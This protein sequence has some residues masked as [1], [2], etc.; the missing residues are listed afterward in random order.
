MKIHHLNC[1]C[2]CPV[3]GR[4]APS[5]FPRELVCHCLLI[6][7]NAGL[8]LVDTGFSTDFF[9]D[10]KYLVERLAFGLD[11]EKTVPIHQ[12]IQDLGFSSADVQHVIAT[13]LDSDHVGAIYEFPNAKYHI[14]KSEMEAYRS[15]RSIAEKVRYRD[16][17]I[18][19]DSEWIFHGFENGENWFG[20]KGV[21]AIAELQD[22]ILLIPLPGHTRG[23]MGVA[24]RQGDQ[25]LFHVGDSYYFRR[26]LEEG[27]SWQ[28][29]IFLRNVHVDFK[30]A[31]KNLLRLF[32]MREFHSA[33]VQM[34]SSHDPGEFK[35]LSKI[36]AQDD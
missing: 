18:K 5:V 36:K 14:S 19:N 32:Q 13:H 25:W 1:G 21:S 11:T 22:Q 15:P 2:L 3:G 34:F 9:T 17:K 10:T 31:I 26:E 8:V 23:H 30:M 24:I 7:S 27:S 4:Y 16:F 6:E 20:F 12:Q 33:E 28:E 29:Q 35:R